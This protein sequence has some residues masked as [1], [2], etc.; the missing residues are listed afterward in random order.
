MNAN[1]KLCKRLAQLLTDTPVAE[2]QK[3]S[4]AVAANLLSRLDVVGREE[5]DAHCEMLSQAVTQVAK[6]EE[7]IR[8]LEKMNEDK[9]KH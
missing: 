5:F 8:Q 2:W 6:L 4:R 9:I 3:N 1:D 7:K